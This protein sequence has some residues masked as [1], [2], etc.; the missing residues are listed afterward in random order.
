MTDE[1]AIDIA[2]AS[3]RRRHWH[4]WIGYAA[5]AWSLAYG[6]LG[7]YWA[8]GGAG[9]PFGVGDEELM[10]EPEYAFKASFLG[11]ATPETAGP[12][13][14]AL[15]ALG[16]AAGVLMARGYRA[17]AAPWLL[18]AFAWTTAVGLTVVV[19]D[20]RPLVVIAYTPILL[21]SK[22]FFG[23]PEG[24]GWADLYQPERVNLL[25]LLLAG[26]AWALTAV[27]YRRRIGDACGR[28]GR[29][30]DARPSRLQRWARPAAW[31]AFAVPLVYCVTRW[32]WA[33][34]F[35]L[36]IDPEFFRQGQEN[37][38]WLAGAALA[39]MGGIG[40]VLTLGLI[41]RWGEVFPRW[42]IGLRGKR[43]PP[44][45]AVVPATL[46]AVLVTSAGGMYLRVVA[47]DGVTASTWPL[48]LP[49][50][51]WGVWGAALFIAAM[52]YH[53]RRRETCGDCGGGAAPA[54]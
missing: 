7:L 11:L 52:A 3:P 8:L 24:A 25:V 49:E 18:P 16:A 41:Q 36:G 1:L 19:Q 39:T 29:T 2:T 53:Q 30:D 5:A 46:A 14:A 34:G 10:S 43:V 12:I 54:A 48:S 33:L 21:V 47:A 31:T 28:C 40:A 32:A 13:I 38:L 35:S 4:D 22:T 50:T 20:Y 26:A 6:A 42:M 27:A 15:G 44:M 37:G 45:L 23:W 17:G 9:F 51:L